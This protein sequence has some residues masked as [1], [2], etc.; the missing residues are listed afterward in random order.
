[1]IAYLFTELLSIGKVGESECELELVSSVGL[2]ASGD[3]WG[4]W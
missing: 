1:M 4:D 3:M 2:R